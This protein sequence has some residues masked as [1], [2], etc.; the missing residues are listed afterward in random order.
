MKNQKLQDDCTRNSVHD[1][2][3]LKSKDT[4]RRN[5]IKSA[6]AITAVSVIPIQAGAAINELKTLSVVSRKKKIGQFKG[7]MPIMTTPVDKNHK[8]D[9]VSQR[10][11]VDYCIQAGAVAIGHF[12]H[13][14]EFKKINDTDWTRLLE[15][16]VNQVDGRVPFYAGITGRTSK[17]I[18]RFAHE[19]EQKGADMIMTSL[20]Y[21]DTIDQ[22]QTL[23]MF[24]DL[25]SACS[26][27]IMIQDLNWKTP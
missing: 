1:N 20:P 7:I 14:S 9:L 15:V 26:L 5:F 8:I 19:S 24:N 17:D 22:I 6:V 13:A 27:P 23:A 10:R 4:P 3:G 16:C 2:D 11:H 18:I 12:A 21:G 25:A